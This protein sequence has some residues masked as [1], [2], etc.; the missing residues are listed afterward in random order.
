[1][2]P[3]DTPNASDGPLAATKPPEDRAAKPTG[4]ASRTRRDQPP[5]RRQPGTHSMI[6]AGATEPQAPTRSTAPLS[7]V[8]AMRSP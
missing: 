6:A 2:T 8:G 7:G 3:A 4:N 1:M 5:A